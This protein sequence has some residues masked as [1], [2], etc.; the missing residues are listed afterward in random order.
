MRQE[1]RFLT[2]IGVQPCFVGEVG[3]EDC[4][5]G[6]IMKACKSCPYRLPWQGPLSCELLANSLAGM[7]YSGKY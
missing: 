2:L 7:Q 1:V 5:I 6:I 3:E 4:I